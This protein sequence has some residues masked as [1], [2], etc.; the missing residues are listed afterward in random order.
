MQAVQCKKGFSLVFCDLVRDALLSRLLKSR[1]IY[2]HRRFLGFIGFSDLS[3]K[4]RYIS[5]VH[6]S[7]CLQYLFIFDKKLILLSENMNMI[8]IKRKYLGKG[9]IFGLSAWYAPHYSTGI[10]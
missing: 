7:I 2:N 8:D 9:L 3:H 10:S 4:A 1:A 5:L 6:I